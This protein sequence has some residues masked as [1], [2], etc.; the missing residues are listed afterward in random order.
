MNALD[1]TFVPGAA[2]LGS[3][4]APIIERLPADWKTRTFDLPG[5]GPVPPSPDVQSYD[6]LV[7]LVARAIDAPTVLVG[8][9][10][11]AYLS[12]KLALA[13]PDL[14]RRLV[15]VVATAGVDMARHGAFDWRPSDRV[16]NPERPAWVHAP[17]DDL[18]AELARIDVP[19]LLIWATRDVLS[20]LGVAH[21]L[22]AHLPHARLVTFDSDD[23]WVARR[24]AHETANV[25]REWLA[26]LEG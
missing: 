9:S 18:S 25:L 10:M 24:F 8:Q 17:P 7:R 5:L 11:G 23:H 6:D 1:L 14:V 13:R 15:L 19:V 22:E 4:W 21:E 2:G 12:L 3:F 16:E 20:P 26:G